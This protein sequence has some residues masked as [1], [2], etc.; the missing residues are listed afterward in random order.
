MELFVTSSIQ[1]RFHFSFEI[2]KHNVNIL[3][4]IKIERKEQ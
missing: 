2:Q 1:G 4:V 3:K